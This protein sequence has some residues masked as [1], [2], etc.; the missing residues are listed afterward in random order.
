MTLI[1][2]LG[3]PLPT[4]RKRVGTEFKLSEDLLK[5][6]SN[7]DGL[8]ANLELELEIQNKI[9]AAALKLLQDPRAPKGV[10]KQRKASYQQSL[11]RLQELGK[12]NDN[13]FALFNV[14]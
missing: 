2:S 10:K 5:Q 12:T 3:E 7:K 14:N 11:K 8:K 6:D 1:Y 4:I 13:H 9:T